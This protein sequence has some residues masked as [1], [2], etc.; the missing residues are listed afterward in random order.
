LLE[1]DQRRLDALV[2]VAFETADQPL[3]RPRLVGGVRRQIVV[4]PFGQQGEIG[5]LGHR[6]ESIPQPPRRRA[7]KDN[8]RA[9]TTCGSEQTLSM[10]GGSSGW[11]TWT[12]AMASPPGSARPRWK[13]AML[14]PAS[15]SVVPSAPMKPG[16]SLLRT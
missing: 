8:A 9:R 15:P 5:V 13:V 3:D 6:R 12:S 16:T 10:M 2:A 7:Q 14:T 4:Q 1:F 11:S